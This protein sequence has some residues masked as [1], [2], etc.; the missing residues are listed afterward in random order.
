VRG[1][2]PPAWGVTPTNEGVYRSGPPSYARAMKTDRFTTARDRIL[3]AD[4]ETASVNDVLNEVLGALHEVAAFEGCVLL[5]T[6]SETML[7]FGGLVE[8]WDHSACVPFWD[9]ELLDPDFSKFNALA[10]SSD[11]V[12]VL[13]DVT[14]GDVARSPRYKLLFEPIGAGDELRVAFTTGASCWAVA[15]LVRPAELGFFGTDEVAA[16]RSLVPVATRA[17][18]AAVMRRDGARS[19]MPPAMLV[20]GADGEIESTTPEADVVLDDFAMAG[21]EGAPPSAVVAA[22]RRAK[23]NRG[24]QR[25]TLRARGSSGRW[26]RVHASPLGTDGRVAIVIE[27]ARPADLVPILLESYGLTPRESEVV[28]LLARGLSTKDIAT[29]LCISRHTVNDHMKLIFAKCGVTSRGEL[30]AKLFSEH[31]M[32]GHIAEVMVR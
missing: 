29:E 23:A 15:S 20:V 7:P 10:R 17:V 4:L 32:D 19:E 13:S 6:D 31:I 9:N 22:A 14:D 18:R 1:S 24:S 11:P 12:A 25:I 26:Y 21:F 16:V 5:L 27:P 2:R 28:P 3:A 30:V 8:S